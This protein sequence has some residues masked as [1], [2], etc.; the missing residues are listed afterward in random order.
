MSRP[1]PFGHPHEDRRARRQSHA[2]RSRV[3]RRKTSEERHVDPRSPRVLIGKHSEK[4]P[5]A[6]R[7]E[8]LAEV[9]LDLERL[10][11]EPPAHLVQVGVAPGIR[12]ARE[13]VLHRPEVDAPRGAQKLPVSEVSGDE[14]RPFP[15]A[16]AR[17]HRLV[18]LPRDAGRDLF[19]CLRGERQKFEERPSQLQECRAHDGGG[20]RPGGE[21]SQGL[22]DVLLRDLP[23][24]LQEAV[25]EGSD[26]GAEVARALKGK[27]ARRGTEG[28]KKKSLEPLAQGAQRASRHVRPFPRGGRRRPVPGARARPARAARARRWPPRW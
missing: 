21:R 16:R 19:A 22:L 28:A 17:L 7:P 15:L 9:G 3:G 14:H 8:R 2:G 12:L 18:A 26:A 5:G 25:G 11:A 4:R 24:S 20:R 23:S 13:Q 10:D 1:V 27:R 6:E